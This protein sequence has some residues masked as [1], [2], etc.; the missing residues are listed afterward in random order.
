MSTRYVWGKYTREAKQVLVDGY[1]EQKINAGTKKVND[2]YDSDERTY[3]FYIYRSIR[4]SQSNGSISGS[5]GARYYT[6]DYSNGGYVATGYMSVSGDSDGYKWLYG[7][8]YKGNDIWIGG[9]AE[10]NPAYGIQSQYYTYYDT[11]YVRGS[12]TGYVTSSNSGQYP[13]DDYTGSNWYV[14][15]GSDSIDAKS[16]TIPSQID[17]GAMINISIEPATNLLGSTTIS[18]V[19]QYRFND[20]T[21]TTLTTTTTTQYTLSVPMDTQ[22]V[23][24]RVQAKDNVGFTSTDY[25]TSET[26]SVTNGDPPVVSSDLGS[27]P[28]D[29][30]QVSEPFTFE[31][32][33]TDPDY[34]DSATVEETLYFGEDLGTATSEKENIL[35]GSKLSFSLFQDLAKKEELTVDDIFLLVPN[36]T[37]LYASVKAVD[38]HGLESEEYKVTFE[39]YVDEVTIK[40]DPPLSVTGSIT[41]GVVYVNGYIPTD[42]EFYVHVTNNAKDEEPVWQDITADVL[43]GRVFKLTNAKA[44][45]GASFSFI[46]H[47]KRGESKEGGFIDSVV[48]AFG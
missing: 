26:V 32:T 20:G 21:W 47:A 8:W 24:V 39:K 46:V 16:V 28:Y 34:G 31:Y 12:L 1:K 22:T 11:Y 3:Y 42:A 33:I 18:Y 41:N 30:G 44:E 17:G 36:E 37:P 38:S 48:G 40:L 27:S 29:M 35:S 25:T 4:I 43:A 13:N 14:K 10:S 9:Y 19:I 6:S 23:Q 2:Y 5:S 7:T 15:L 45:S